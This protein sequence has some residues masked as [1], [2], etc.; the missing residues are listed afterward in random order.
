MQRKPQPK[1]SHRFHLEKRPVPPPPPPDEHRR[2]HHRRHSRLG[3]FFMCVGF[4][5]VCLLIFR[6]L[7]VPVLVY[8]G[9][10]A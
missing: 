9:G 2:R 3:I 8:L 4:I 1:D 5:T 10:G 6:F 7:I